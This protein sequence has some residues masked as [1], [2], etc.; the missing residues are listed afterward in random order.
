I[1]LWRHRRH[2]AAP[3][4]R[5]Y[6]IF[7]SIAIC[8]IVCAEFLTA[9]SL[10]LYSSTVNRQYN[11][12]QRAMSE[13]K[14]DRTKPQSEYIQPIVWRNVFL[15]GIFHI[16]AF[17][18]LCCSFFERKPLLLAWG[19]TVGVLSGIGVTAGAHRLWTHRAYKAKW[20]L[21]LILLAFYSIAGQNS[22][23]DWVRDHRLHHQFSDTDCDPH[24]ATRGFFFSHVG[25][26][27]YRKHPSVIEKGR[28]ID[29]SDILADPLVTFHSRYFNFI[30]ILLCFVFPVGIPIWLWNED[31]YSSMLYI[32][33]LRYI[34]G[35]NCTWSVNSVAHIW[36]YKPYNKSIS[37]AENNFVALAAMGEGFHNYHHCFPWDYKAAELGFYSLNI[38][39]LFIDF[40]ARIGWAYDLKTASDEM[41]KLRVIASGDGTHPSS[42]KEHLQ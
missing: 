25:W 7:S 11:Q 42:T 17:Y 31:F 21:R 24:N 19:I 39:T 6:L 36:G 2:F 16:I 8:K 30:K 29:M 18:A 12:K 38:T 3:D 1:A 27:M 28:M 37:P 32:G 35:L 23:F 5:E 33:I 10:G 15:I 4:L 13:T 40:F 20:P 41:V 26:L 14:M 34:I 9:T 22:I